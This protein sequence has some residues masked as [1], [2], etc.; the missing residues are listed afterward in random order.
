MTSISDGSS[1]MK[2]LIEAVSW[3]GTEVTLSMFG[4]PRRDAAD[5]HLGRPRA[6]APARAHVRPPR[7]G[8]RHRGWDRPRARPHVDG[9]LPDDL[10]GIVR[11]CIEAALSQGS[12]AVWF[13]FEGSFDFDHLLSRDIAEQIYAVGS[14]DGVELALADEHR[15]SERWRERLDAVRQYLYYMQNSP[16]MLSSALAQLLAG[17]LHQDWPLDY[18]TVWD[19]VR[20]FRSGEP[21]VLVAEA[22]RQALELLDSLDSDDELRRILTDELASGYWPPADGL[23]FRGWLERVAAEL[24]GPE[25][26]RGPA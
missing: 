21:T 12:P 10:P 4:G 26:R 25:P 16:V 13:G 23:T 1:G 11:R 9:T 17:Y 15:G 14:A 2:R 8:G 7:R 24:A 5:S 19:A 22:R 18:S 20:A 6:A 3:S